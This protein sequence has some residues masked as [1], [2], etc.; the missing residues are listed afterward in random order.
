MECITKHKVKK[1]YLTCIFHDIYF[2]V[3]YVDIEISSVSRMQLRAQI[4]PE[5]TRNI[6]PALHPVSVHTCKLCIHSAQML[7]EK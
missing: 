1:F 4:S 6:W 5:I 3:N 2:I 7:I